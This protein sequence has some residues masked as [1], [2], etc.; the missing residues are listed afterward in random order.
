MV[1]QIANFLIQ[2]IGAWAIGALIF[3]AQH[4]FMGF[5]ANISSGPDEEKMQNWRNGYMTVISRA[6][7]ILFIWSLGAMVLLALGWF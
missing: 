2:T 6:K 1:P 4:H 3:V 5:V 7:D